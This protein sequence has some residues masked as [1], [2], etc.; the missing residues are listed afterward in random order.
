MGEPVAVFVFWE[1]ITANEFLNT[2]GTKYTKVN[3]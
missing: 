2:K 1:K 3:L